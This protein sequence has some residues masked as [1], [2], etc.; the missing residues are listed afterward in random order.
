MKYCLSVLVF[1]CAI[2]GCSDGDE[3]I[4]HASPEIQDKNT[5]LISTVKLSVDQ[6]EIDIASIY[7]D[8]MYI[9]DRLKDMDK[10]ENTV[11]DNSIVI[12]KIE[13]IDFHSIDILKAKIAYLENKDKTDLEEE[14][15]KI[16]KIKN[17]TKSKKIKPN[18]YV[19]KVNNWGGAL[20][21]I[22]NI[23][24]KGFETLSVYSSVGGGWV[25]SSI[26][27]KSVSFLHKSG[28]ISQVFL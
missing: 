18:I 2:S 8:V 23:P 25:I 22:V 24:G 10:I 21:A 9:L 28:Q 5:A 17:K 26:E 27:E 13:S 1:V 20:V 15:K 16:S 3:N 19:S 6:N 14:K 12:E 7:K 11:L 4:V